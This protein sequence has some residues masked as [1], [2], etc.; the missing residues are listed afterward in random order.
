MII[1]VLESQGLMSTTAIA[2]ATLASVIITKDRL[3]KLEEEGLV[4]SFQTP[5]KYTYWKLSK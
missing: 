4:E 5:T 1:E 3:N 2:Q